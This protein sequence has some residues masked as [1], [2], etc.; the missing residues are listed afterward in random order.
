[1]VSSNANNA[2]G[3]E[4][5]LDLKPLLFDLAFSLT[6]EFLLG[7]AASTSS[8]EGQAFADAFNTAFKWIAKRERLKSAYWLIDSLEFRRSCNDARS[9][10]DNIIKRTS[11]LIEDSSGMESRIALFRLLHDDSET[12]EIR[13]QFL[14]FL[15]AGRDTSGALMSWCLYV[16]AREPRI[17]EDLRA[18]IGKVVG[19]RQP[20][21][22]DFRKLKL[23]DQFLNEGTVPSLGIRFYTL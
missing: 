1:M 10:V 6:T 23:L 18:E 15:L 9:R 12:S 5:K 13:D 16:L 21:K 14:G 19:G 8:T 17:F 7:P 4:I 20:A 11:K 22:E 3:D 2:H